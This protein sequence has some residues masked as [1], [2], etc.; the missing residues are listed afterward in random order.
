M[1]HSR[2]CAVAL[3]IVA[4]ALDAAAAPAEIL[5]DQ[6]IQREQMRLHRRPQDAGAYLRLGDAY[7][8]KARAT[9]DM[10]YLGLAEESLRKS[11]AISPASAGATR[12]LA[13]VFSTRHEFQAAASQALRAIDL[14]PRDG[15]A[16]G[17]LGDAYLEL[18]AYDRA[19]AAFD[20]MIRLKGDLA[21]YARLSGLESLRGNPRGAIDNLRRAI[22]SGRSTSQPRESIAWAEWQLGAEHF[23]IGEV[24]AA[25]AQ[26]EAALRTYSGYYRAL[27]GLAQ[28]RAAQGR[29]DDAVVLYGKALAVTPFP[30]YA[31]ALGDLYTKMGRPAE[32][33]KQ[34]DL[35]EYIGRLNTLNKV[36]YN[37]ELAYFYADHDVK[38]DAA[39]ELARSELAGRQDIYGYDVL[40]WALHKSGRSQEALGPMDE[41]LRLGTRDA[42]L[43]FHAGMIHRALGNRERARSYLAQALAVNPHF[44]V[45]QA[46]QA[47][48]ALADLVPGGARVA[49]TGQP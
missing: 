48:R 5:P 42:K 7:V 28:V 24:G 6:A 23:A 4:A 11:L 43:F 25:E 37:R 34:Y 8:Q 1:R 3:A 44:H 39:V 30:E 9:G 16:F 32:A 13:Y 22:A 38:L 12:H 17:V 31:T 18:G 29:H 33:R 45:L 10:S 20:E 47:V 40:A 21:S 46:D 36:L 14:D 2:F 27:G 26:H 15:D 49:D 41:A 19:A 35:V